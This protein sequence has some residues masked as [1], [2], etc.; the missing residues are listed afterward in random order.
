[1][2]AVLSRDSFNEVVALF[3][4]YGQH[5]VSTALRRRQHDRERKSVA[6]P[7]PL[8]PKSSSLR[9]RSSYLDNL[10]GNAN[11]ASDSGVASNAQH[12]PA[13]NYNDPDKSI[14]VS[15]NALVGS[16]TPLTTSNAVAVGLTT[17]FER[18]VNRLK[19]V[20]K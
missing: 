16:S 3:P 10:I 18:A 20:C 9:R 12:I 8:T 11:V 2:L 15:P 14:V 17:S 4:E 1:M 5:I 19:R 13:V 6:F 7:E